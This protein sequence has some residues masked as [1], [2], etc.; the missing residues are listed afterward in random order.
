MKLSKNTARIV[1]GA[2]MAVGVSLLITNPSLTTAFI[3]GIA[4]CTLGVVAA[5]LTK[6]QVLTSPA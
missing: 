4:L 1:S 3:M 6:W 5:L 2:I